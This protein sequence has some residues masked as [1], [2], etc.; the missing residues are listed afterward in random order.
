MDTKGLIDNVKSGGLFDNA[1]LIKK[2]IYD[3]AI[4]VLPIICTDIIPV[5]KI[6]HGYEIG[7]IRRATGSQSGKMALIGGR[8]RKDQSIKDAISTHLRNDLG[9]GGWDFFKNN[10]ENNPFFVQQYFQTESA[11]DNNG[12][13]PSK[14]A[15]ALTYLVSIHDEPKP[16]NEAESFM[17]IKGENIPSNTAYNQGV[18][19]QKAFDF[20]SEDK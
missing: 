12:F 20:L 1:G 19:M 5:K 14:H 4:D 15:V 7:I 11:E 10:S 8:V 6:N 16:A 9:I 13:D 3:L 2:P 17:W 18:V